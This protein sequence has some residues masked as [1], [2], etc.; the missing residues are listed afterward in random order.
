[1]SEQIQSTIEVLAAK[2]RSKEEEALKLKKLVNELCAELG[3]PERYSGLAHA[4]STDTSLR[5][6]HFYG[7]TLT[8]A[9]RTYLEMRKSANLGAASVA[10]IYQAMRDGGYKFETKNEENAKITLR[11]V[12][13][14]SS[15]VFH[16]LPTGDYGLLSWYPNAKAPKNQVKEDENDEGENAPKSS[17][18]HASPPEEPNVTTNEEVRDA[19]FSMSGE[20][21]KADVEK[22]LKEKFPTKSPRDTQIAVEIFKLKKKGFFRTVGERRGS[23][24]AVYVKA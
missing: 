13:R 16:R 4:A 5:K 7:M 17:A 23:V 18:E 12:L 20:F 6:D 3:V 8:S 15:S 2:V 10:E 22:K 9:A 14:K 24:G 21:S 19:I 11:G 1:M